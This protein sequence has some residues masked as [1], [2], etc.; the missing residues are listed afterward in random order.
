M[1]MTSIN[2]HQLDY[3]KLRYALYVRKSTDDASKQFRSL[4]DQ[5]A[6]FEAMARRLGIR[7]V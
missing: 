1:T 6:E 7:L 4:K 5:I 3:T 2:F